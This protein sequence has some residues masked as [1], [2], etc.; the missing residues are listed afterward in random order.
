MAGPARFDLRAQTLTRDEERVIADRL[1]DGAL[2]I[3]PTDTLYA[4]GCRALDG[5]AV[6]RLRAAK[7]REEAKALPIIV[8]DPAE[9]PAL[10]AAWPEEARRLA[11]AFWPG[12][13]TLVLPAGA[14]LPAELL[15]GA[16]GIALRVPDSAS[17]RLLAGLTGPLVATSANLAGAPPCSTLDLAVSAFPVAALA[18]DGGPLDGLPSTL[19]E[20]AGHGRPPRVLREG[21]I[22]RAAIE[23]VLGEAVSIS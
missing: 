18:F 2:I 19:L 7:G 11:A 4:I 23:R 6:G 17:A 15:A 13:L 14:N 20:V 16:P 10:A 8:S 9:A 12:P 1:R 3:Y 22:S 21:R 5:A